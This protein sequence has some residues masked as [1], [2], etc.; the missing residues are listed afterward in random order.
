MEVPYL[1]PKCT[2]CGGS[3]ISASQP[4]VWIN[5]SWC[6][7]GEDMHDFW[8]VTCCDARE[9]YVTVEWVTAEGEA[10]KPCRKCDRWMRKS[11][12]AGRRFCGSCRQKIE[13]E[14]DLDRMGEAYD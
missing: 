4:M 2:T 7:G 12:L 1:Y 3:E 10:W 9:P 11:D 8:C 5:D 6:D 13:F 14:M